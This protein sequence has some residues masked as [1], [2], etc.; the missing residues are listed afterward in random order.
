VTLAKLP[1]SAS[2]LRDLRPRLLSRRERFPSKLIFSKLR[3]T[4]KAIFMLII[5]ISSLK[6]KLIID[7]KKGESLLLEEI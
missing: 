6:F 7:K 2:Y 3:L 1:R 5:W 4:S